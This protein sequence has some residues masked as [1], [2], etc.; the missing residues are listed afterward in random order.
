MDEGRTPGDELL[1]V[2][3]VAAYLD[4][5]PTTVYRWCREGRLPCLKLGKS[6]R[7]RRSALDGFL[8]GAERRRTLEDHLRGFLVV[9]DFVI[10][11]AENDE[12]MARLDAAFFKVGEAAGGLLVKLHGGVTKSMEE[13]REGLRRYGFDV[14]ALEATGRFRWSVEVDPA[15]RA[16]TLQRVLEAEQAAGRTVWASFNWTKRV[17]LPTVLA[18]QEALASVVG[19]NRAVVKTAV[20]Q[21]VADEWSPA[22]LRGAQRLHRGQIRLSRAGVVLSRE[23]PLPED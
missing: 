18:Q 21:D 1:G 4:V 23:V 6:W 16:V 9:P 17:D 3:D 20:V 5:R 19:D 2:V 13:L 15:E 12:L 7:I 8:A 11:I 22:E 10:A 14:D